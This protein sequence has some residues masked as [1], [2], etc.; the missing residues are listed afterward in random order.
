MALREAVTLRAH[1]GCVNAVAFNH[2]GNYCLTAGDDRRVLLWNP[3]REPEE[4]APIKE[5]TGH[6]QRVLDV[7]VAAGNASFASCGGDRTVFVWDVASGVISRR[8]QAH[9][10]RVN[11]VAYNDD[12]SILLSASYDKS[13]RCWDM[14]SKNVYPV[15][16]LEGASDSVSAVACAGPFIYSSSIDGAVRAYDLRRGTLSVDQF[17]QPV[18]HVALSHDGN[19]VLAST[20]DSKLRLLD[21]ADGQLL[22][23]Y[24]GHCNTSFKLSCCLS[25]DDA[26]TLCGSEDGSVHVW[27]L[28]EA[29]RVMRL[30]GHRQPV[31][32]ISCHPARWELLTASH[33]GTAKLWKVP[34]GAG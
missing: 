34:G 5:Y 32:A 3:H 16:T 33:D 4:M 1:K 7:A 21:K 2:D 22:T 28:V 20:L 6:S 14:R 24:T 27:D 23:E 30:G 13:V 26:F 19:C 15:Q 11:A 12:C 10:Q 31:A 29:K 17:G 9:E 8:L 18:T 25:H